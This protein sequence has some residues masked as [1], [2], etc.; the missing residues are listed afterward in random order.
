VSLVLLVG[1]ALLIRSFQTVIGEDPGFDPSDVNVAPVSLSLLRYEEEQDHVEFYR[2][3]LRRIQGHSAVESAGVLSATPLY[4][5]V[6]P[7]GRMEL[8]GDPAKQTVGHYVV[9]SRGAFSA[10]DIPL[11]QGR[12]FEETDG[13]GNAHVA[14]VSESFARENWPDQDPIGRQ[15]TGGGMDNFYEDRVFARVV[16]V[17]GDVRFRELGGTEQPTVY[18]PY[19]QRPFRIQYGARLVVETTSVEPSSLIPDLRATIREADP[20]IPI[21]VRTYRS[22]VRESL[23]ERRFVTMILGGFSVLALVLAAV[24]IFGVVSY[25]VARRTREM[26]IRLAL[27]ADPEDVLRTVLG[28]VMGMVLGG[29]VVGFVGALALTRTLES[30]LYQV[31]P[32][33]PLSLAVGVLGLAATALM[34]AWIPARAGTRVDPMITMQGE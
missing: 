30:L 15:V 13:P 26:G 34:A 23:G 18:F 22:V 2:E 6:P 12:L 1:S 17:V 20:E 21:S 8:D 28:P 4:G 31:T 5:G 25:V 29:L 33:D 32:L 9:A 11:L 16:G 19:H 10:L 14:L 7:N 24:G 3:L 27:G